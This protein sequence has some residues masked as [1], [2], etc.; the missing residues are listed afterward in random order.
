MVFSQ[1]A[2]TTWVL[3]LGK[4]WRFRLWLRFKILRNLVSLKMLFVLT[5]LPYQH[6]SQALITQVVSK[7][8]HI[9]ATSLL[10]FGAFS[11]IPIK[12]LQS[13]GDMNIPHDKNWAANRKGKRCL[14]LL[15]CSLPLLCLS[16][17]QTS[18]PWKMVLF[19]WV[20]YSLFSS[21]AFCSHGSLGALHLYFL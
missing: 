9:P 17:S 16:P 3:Y 13:P 15:E 4:E 14:Q 18:E 21:Q 11:Y 12:D 6:D 1:I 7:I 2:A 5:F 10:W 20:N 19:T 8:S